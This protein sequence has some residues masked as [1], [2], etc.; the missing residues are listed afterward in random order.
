MTKVKSRRLKGPYYQAI[1]LVAFFVVFFVDW[2]G[3]KNLVDDIV[4][5]AIMAAIP[6]FALYYGLGMANMAEAG[7]TKK[8]PPAKHTL[9]SMLLNNT[10]IYV[11]LYIA[12]SVTFDYWT[13][14]FTKL[15]TQ[16][17]ALGLIILFQLVLPGGRLDP[18]RRLAA[19][20]GSPQTLAGD[21][22]DGADDKGK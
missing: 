20:E 22:E 7:V 4:F 13:H 8:S 19:A 16:L 14:N 6:V 18:D 10:Y 21:T 3:S 15:P 5:V 2:T 1:I 17:V 11:G 12:I 9:W